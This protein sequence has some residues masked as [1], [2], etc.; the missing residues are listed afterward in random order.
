MLWNLMINQESEPNNSPEMPALL[1]MV[2]NGP[3]S[4]E[5]TKC[6]YLCVHACK[7]AR[8]CELLS[9]QPPAAAYDTAYR[10]TLF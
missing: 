1:A 6:T 4:W 8:L 7:Y 9:K 2:S 10:S 5:R 3:V